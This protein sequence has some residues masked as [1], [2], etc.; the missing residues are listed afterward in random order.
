MSDD[1]LKASRSA[2]QADAIDEIRR[3]ILSGGDLDDWR[4]AFT[5]DALMALY[6]GLYSLARA[7]A[8]IS[9]TPPSQHIPFVATDPF[10]RDTT[11][12]RL[13]VMLDEIAAMEVRLYPVFGFH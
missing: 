2:E 6:C 8:L 7:N 10:V 3:A 4:K 9:L 13:M 5:V 12:E 11:K 1:I